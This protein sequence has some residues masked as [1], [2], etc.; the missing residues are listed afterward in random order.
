MIYKWGNVLLLDEMLIKGPPV[1][2]ATFFSALKSPKFPSSVDLGGLPR[3]VAIAPK[4]NH[5]S[6]FVIIFPMKIYMKST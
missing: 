2:G 5:F 3:I 6:S 4:R 1:K